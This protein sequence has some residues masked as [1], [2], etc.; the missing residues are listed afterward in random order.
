MCH[1]RH[2]QSSSSLALYSCYLCGFT[3]TSPSIHH[4][5][6]PFCA[7]GRVCLRVSAASYLMS[8]FCLMACK[9]VV[10]TVHVNA[11]AVF[12]LLVFSLNVSKKW[13][14]LKGFQIHLTSQN[15]ASTCMEFIKIKVHQESD[16]LSVV[17]K[18]GHIDIIILMCPSFC[19]QTLEVWQTIHDFWHS[20]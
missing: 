5:F 19:L 2:R 14:H 7:K 20:K 16:L 13:A 6:L 3:P 17:S 10:T 9:L 12:K 18:Q 15:C 8:W 4:P 11:L 1:I